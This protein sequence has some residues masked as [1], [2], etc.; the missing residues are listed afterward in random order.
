[1]T[2][3]WR[4]KN[5]IPDDCNEWFAN[6][7]EQF[8]DGC[9]RFAIL[10]D[11]YVL[12]MSYLPKNQSMDTGEKV[13]ERSQKIHGSLRVSAGNNELW[14]V[15]CGYQRVIYGGDW[16]RDDDPQGLLRKIHYND[17]IMSAMSF[18]ITSLTIFYSTVYSMRISKKTSKLRITGLCGGNMTH[19]ADPNDPVDLAFGNFVS[20]WQNCQTRHRSI[21]MD[22]HGLISALLTYDIINKCVNFF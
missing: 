1:M 3:S 10:K 11:C 7:C 20:L 9:E 16:L 13:F 22:A 6:S 4:P 15:I 21:N 19:F 8:T 18:Q 5:Y 17:V 14:L 12:S 2:S